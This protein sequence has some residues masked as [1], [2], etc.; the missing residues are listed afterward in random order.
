MEKSLKALLSAVS[1]RPPKTHDIDYLADQLEEAGVEVPMREE[2]SALTLYAVE[3]RY[4]EPPITIEEAE[5]ACKVA[6]AF[7]GTVE[8]EME[9]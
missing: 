2:I 5:Y 1:R 6:R 8:K 4:P 3:A 7:P 9:H